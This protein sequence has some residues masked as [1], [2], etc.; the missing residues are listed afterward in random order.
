MFPRIA[1][2]IAVV[3]VMFLVGFF[4]R[5]AFEAERTSCRGGCQR[6]IAVPYQMLLDRM[7]AL[8]DAGRN[9]EL[10]KL[11]VQAQEHAGDVSNTCWEPQKD[12]YAMEVYEWTR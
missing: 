5:G 1:L 10:R 6:N 3:L 2:T 4:V 8:A 11:I 9:D 12:V 7:R